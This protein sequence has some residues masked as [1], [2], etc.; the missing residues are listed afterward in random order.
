MGVGW[1]LAR[2]T[3]L[4]GSYIEFGFDLDVSWTPIKELRLGGY[5]RLLVMEFWMVVLLR[6]SVNAQV[7]QI[8]KV[9]VPSMLRRLSV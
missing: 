5:L 3:T 4:F 8:T 2:V 6:T 1:A 9:C 7:I